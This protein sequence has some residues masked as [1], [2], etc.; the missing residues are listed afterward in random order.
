MKEKLD[1]DELFA[2]SYIEHMGNATA[3]ARET[4]KIESGAY[5]SKKGSEMV[6]KS[7]VRNVIN[8]YMEKRKATHEEFVEQTPYYLSVIAHKLVRIIENDNTSFND[9]MRAIEMLSRLCGVELSE[10]VVIAQIKSG[11]WRQ[12]NISQEE[13]D[14]CT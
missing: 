9:C 6:R 2:L 4:F 12:N 3:A 10:K 5:A 8:E 13:I 14:T 1:T 11:V 7:K